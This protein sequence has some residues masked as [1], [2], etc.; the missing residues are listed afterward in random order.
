MQIRHMLPPVYVRYN[1]FLFCN[2]I[3]F[4]F[5]FCFPLLLGFWKHPRGHCILPHSLET[6]AGLPWCL[7]QLGTLPAGLY[8]GIY[9]SNIDITYSSFSPFCW[10]RSYFSNLSPSRHSPRLC[11]TGQ[12]T[13]SGW[14]SLWASWPTS[15]IRT[16]CLQCTRTTACCIHSLTASAR[17]SPNA[18]ETFAWTRYTHWSKQVNFNSFL[19]GGW[20]VAG[21]GSG[22]LQGYGEGKGWERNWMY[23]TL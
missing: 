7:L 23:L 11:V 10:I 14:R 5:V 6:Q 21:D 8:I 9:L 12:I 22:C 18:T 20:K 1:V 3:H 4:D 16:A 19:G 13:T 2:F 15:W 17:P